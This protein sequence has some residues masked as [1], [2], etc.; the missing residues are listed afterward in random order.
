[1][2]EVVVDASIVVQWVVE[3]DGSEDARALLERWLTEGI[4]PIAPSW[5]TCEIANIL[6]K[7]EY[8]L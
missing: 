8:P 6:Y 7:R 3:E 2:P 5:L 1:M 4:Q